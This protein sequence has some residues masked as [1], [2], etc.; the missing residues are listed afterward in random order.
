MLLVSGLLGYVWEIIIGHDWRLVSD[1]AIEYKTNRNKHKLLH[2]HVIFF[3]NC[4]DLEPTIAADQDP[5]ESVVNIASLVTA[6]HTL[7]VPVK[8][9]FIIHTLRVPV[10]H[11]FIIDS[12]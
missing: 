8:H 3:N 5:L 9:V 12:R 7:R 6:K 2:R 10:K 1:T 11:V 4:I